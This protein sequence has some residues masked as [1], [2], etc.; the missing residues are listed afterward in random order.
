[1]EI[2][3]KRI[4][5]VEIKKYYVAADGTEFASEEECRKYEDTA[6]CAINAMFEKLEMQKTFCVGDSIDML[7]PFS[8]D[9][10]MYAVKV[11]DINDV[12]T[13]NKW[14]KAAHKD[15]AVLGAETIGTIQ[16]LDM[17]DCS[18]VWCIGTP[19]DLKAKYARAVDELVDKLVEKTE[20]GETA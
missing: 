4:E 2:K 17:Y 19:D 7:T 5:R 8:Y 11:R 12:E 16:L 1:M 6:R 14:I 9:D 3:E 10:N 20:E 18:S 15:N 13:I